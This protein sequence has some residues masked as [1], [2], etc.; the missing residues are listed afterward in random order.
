MQCLIGWHGRRVER[1]GRGPPAGTRNGAGGEEGE[2]QGAAGRR[3]RRA[4]RA[5]AEGDVVQEVLLHT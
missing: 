2:E 3:R 5:A 1:A 4:A